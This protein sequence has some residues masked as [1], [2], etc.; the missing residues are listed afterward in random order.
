MV[1]AAREREEV[2]VAVE[3]QAKKLSFSNKTSTTTNGRETKRKSKK[4]MTE[5]TIDLQQV[6]ALVLRLI[7]LRH[8]TI[9][10]ACA[11][12][13][14]RQVSTME[15]ETTENNDHDDHD[16]NHDDRNDGAPSANVPPYVPF[17]WRG[18][19][20]VA[21]TDHDTSSALSEI[22]E[23]V[24][25]WLSELLPLDDNPLLLNSGM[26]PRETAITAKMWKELSCDLNSSSSSS[27]SSSSAMT[28]DWSFPSDSDQTTSFTTKTKVVM[29]L[30]RLLAKTKLAIHETD[31]QL[32]TS[33]SSSSSSSI[34]GEEDKE[35]TTRRRSTKES[36]S[37]EE[38]TRLES[39]NLPPNHI[40]RVVARLL[41]GGLFV[42]EGKIG[43]DLRLSCFV[44]GK[45]RYERWQW[46]R[47]IERRRVETEMHELVSNIVLSATT[48]SERKLNE[49]K[50]KV[51]EWTEK[52]KKMSACIIQSE[53]RRRC[54]V[55]KQIRGARTLYSMWVSKVGRKLMSHAFLS[56]MY[57]CEEERKREE[58]RI[59]ELS[60]K[61]ELL[62]Q[63]LS[64]NAATL[65]QA[66]Y[67]G[68]SGRTRAR[69]R[70]RRWINKIS[71]KKIQR[72][73]CERR[74]LRRRRAQWR[75]KACTTLQSWCRGLRDRIA[76]DRQRNSRMSF[77]W[78]QEKKKMMNNDEDQWSRMIGR[79]RRRK[80]ENGENSPVELWSLRRQQGLLIQRWAQSRGLAGARAWRRWKRWKASLNLERS[81]RG[82]L[83]R[84]EGER[85]REMRRKNETVIEMQRVARGWL[86]CKCVQEK[87]DERRLLLE[88]MIGVEEYTI[89]RRKLEQLSP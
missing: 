72:V 52:E 89:M 7:E 30:G 60:Q 13:Q 21:K 85:R 67:R 8:A 26:P 4:K 80:E 16:N 68:V 86:A 29:M 1:T 78:D 83:G 42:A 46:E 28:R 37:K 11:L 2:L 34:K 64:F 62:R 88:A 55:M 32:L 35:N 19:D 48:C 12:G 38:S 87:R 27:S 23:T 66:W 51:L 43:K 24:A 74:D 73:W 69:R 40:E 10:F 20:Y 45:E 15:A 77:L 17:V 49:R 56:M 58:R 79:R 54:L 75:E 31:K 3:E 14:W 84:R 25:S 76:V 63:R 33:S 61:R 22:P 18:R 9:K 82:W 5:T 81:W 36:L 53:W 70:K 47:E 44:F 57:H 59:H 39:E 6:T 71:A 50:K 65:V 41:E